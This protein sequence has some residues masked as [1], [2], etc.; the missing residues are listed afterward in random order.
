MQLHAVL[1]HVRG[2]DPACD[3]NMLVW[4]GGAGAVPGTHQLDLRPAGLLLLLPPAS[5]SAARRLMMA[6]LS[7]TTSSSRRTTGTW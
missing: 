5:T 6:V 4:R 7:T 1:Y 2:C 3:H